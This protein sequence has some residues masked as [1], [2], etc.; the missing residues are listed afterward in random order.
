MPHASEDEIDN[1]LRRPKVGA[2]M[3]QG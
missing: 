2:E 1:G 3:P